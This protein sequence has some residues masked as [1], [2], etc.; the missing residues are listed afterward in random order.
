M[1][2]SMKI[3]TKILKEIQEEKKKTD[4]PI[5][6][7]FERAW[8]VYKESKYPVKHE[9]EADTQVEINYLNTMAELERERK[10]AR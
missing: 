1:Y 2:T 5:Y 8:K 3:S 7:I 6:K 10:K 4:I 9:Y